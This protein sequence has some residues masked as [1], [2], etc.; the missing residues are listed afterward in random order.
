MGGNLEG[1][2][3]SL[4]YL[5]ELGVECIYLNP[6]FTSP[7]GREFSRRDFAVWC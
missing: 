6:V 7:S 1:I 3:K 5:A 2:R 4:D